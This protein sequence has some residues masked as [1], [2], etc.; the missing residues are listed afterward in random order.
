LELHSTKIFEDLV[1]DT[2]S[3]SSSCVANPKHHDLIF[4]SKQDS[5]THLLRLTPDPNCDFCLKKYQDPTPD[6]LTI[7]LHALSYKVISS[8]LQTK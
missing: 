5:E 7:Y 3:E 4:N 6:K 2:G 1:P 8:N